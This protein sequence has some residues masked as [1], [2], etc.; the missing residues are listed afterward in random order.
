M[1]NIIFRFSFRLS[2]IDFV[3]KFQLFLL[4]K[5]GGKNVVSKDAQCSE[6]D[7]CVLEIFFC[8]LSFSDMVENQP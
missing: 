6:T 5:Y 1:K 4:T 7:F 8:N 3:H 2:L